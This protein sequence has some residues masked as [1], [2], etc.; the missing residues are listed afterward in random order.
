[1]TGALVGLAAALAMLAGVLGGLWWAERSRRLWLERWLAKGRAPS[2]APDVAVRIPRTPSTVDAIRQSPADASPAERLPRTPS[3]G[4][5]KLAEF[6]KGRARE[7]GLTLDDATVQRAARDMLT[8]A[9]EG[10]D[11]S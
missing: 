1:M 11:A 10:R 6:V 3:R 8:Q 9:T 4:I 2:P 5:L 7:K